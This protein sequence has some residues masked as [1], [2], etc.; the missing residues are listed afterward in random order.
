MLVLITN[1]VSFSVVLKK[2]RDDWLISMEK[3]VLIAFLLK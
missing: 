1:I 3:Y 2:L